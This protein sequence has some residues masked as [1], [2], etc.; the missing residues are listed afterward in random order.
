MVSSVFTMSNDD[1]MDEL[2]LGLDCYTFGWQKY[3]SQSPGQVHP[4]YVKK[5]HFE[6]VLP[7]EVTFK[8]KLWAQSIHCAGQT[9]V[10]RIK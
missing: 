9:Y 8:N 5:Y 2:G 7:H 3:N 4:F 6:V 1:E 10:L